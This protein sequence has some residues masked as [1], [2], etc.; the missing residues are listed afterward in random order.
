[1]LYAS[2]TCK[3]VVINDRWNRE[4]EENVDSE[5]EKL[6]IAAGKLIRIKIHE[7]EYN[8][9]SYPKTDDFQNVE[10]A[11]SWIPSLLNLF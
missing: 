4:R 5:A 10:A 2:K 1:M 6:V 11:K 8:M 9:E 3:P 7:T